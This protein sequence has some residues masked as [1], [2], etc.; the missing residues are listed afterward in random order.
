MSDNV[1][2]TFLNPHERVCFYSVLEKEE[3]GEKY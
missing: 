3:G 2:S 1:L